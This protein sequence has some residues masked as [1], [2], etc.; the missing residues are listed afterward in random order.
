MVRRTFGLPPLIPKRKVQ[1]EIV[2][3]LR[4]M[5]R[6]MRRANQPFAQ[7]MSVKFLRVDF[8]VQMIDDAAECHQQ[9]L[10]QQD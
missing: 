9:Q 10:H 4:V 1:T 6:M 2:L 7:R 8:D 5:Q 3:E